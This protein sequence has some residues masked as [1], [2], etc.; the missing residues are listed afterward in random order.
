MITELAETPYP[1]PTTEPDIDPA[2]IQPITVA[3]V[4]ASAARPAGTDQQSSRSQDGVDQ[5]GP[6]DAE[7]GEPPLPPIVAVVRFPLCVAAVQK[8]ED[9]EWELADAIL[10]ECSET[11]A[12]GVRNDSYAKMEAMR[13]EIAKNLGVD[14]S[15]ER[16]RK[17]RKVASAFPPG[18][19]RPGVS[20][21]AHL[22]SGAPE[23][24]DEI[25]AKAPEGT[26]LT[27]AFIRG[28]KNPDEKADQDNQ[29]KERRRQDEDQRKALLKVCK[30]QE[31]EKAQ[32]AQ[33]YIELCH[34]LG[35]EPEPLPAPSPQEAEPSGTVAEDLQHAIQR[36]LM[37][38][39]IDATA[40][41]VKQAIQA[42]VAAVVHEEPK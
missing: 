25:I 22:E 1:S 17:L 6:E 14:L 4:D 5:N 27:R 41:T 36:A 23:A 19:R 32:L 13:E 30:Q 26:P 33:R 37:S 42:F 15:F 20:V 7:Q 39:G 10:A 24:L 9:G 40:E 11:G 18:R 29:K 28:A 31:R 34:S 8:R 35:K 2:S 21:E 12:D 16:I 38:C 3:E